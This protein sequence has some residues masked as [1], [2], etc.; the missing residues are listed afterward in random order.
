MQTELTNGGSPAPSQAAPAGTWSLPSMRAAPT[1]TGPRFSGDGVR[2]KAKLIGVDPVTDA[3]GDKMCLDSMMKL[4]GF[5]QA[6]RR[7]GRHKLKVWLIISF[8]GVKIIDERTGAVLYDHD[9]KLMSSLTRDVTDPRA[10]AYVYQQQDAYLLFYIK[11]ANLA[12][13]VLSDIQHVCQAEDQQTQ[14]KPADVPTQNNSSLFLNHSPTSAAERSELEDIF[15]PQPDQSNPASPSSQLMD[16]F[17]VQSPA[18]SLPGNQPEPPKPMLSNSQILSIYPNY[19]AGGSP[20][21]AHPP[22]PVT[23]M[24]WGQP[25]QGLVGNQWAGPAVAPWPAAAPVW[26]SAGQPVHTQGPPAGAT[27]GGDTP[28]SPMA[29]NGFPSPFNMTA[30]APE[31]VQPT[32]PQLL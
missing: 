20:H 2:Y 7:Q 1:N 15:N 11:T 23:A 18:Q 19:P 13:P 29:V 12:E 14:Q 6:G 22:Y 32:S 25:Q 10:L 21:S 8:S 24:P 30:N 9:R 3:E 31:P 16:A 26:G 4:K 27:S 17:T 5:E 28:T